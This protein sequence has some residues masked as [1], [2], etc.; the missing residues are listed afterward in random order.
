M[1]MTEP[2]VQPGPEDGRLA[3]AIGAAIRAAREAAGLTAIELARLSGV[4]QPHISR[5][6]NGRAEM[7]IPNLY[8]L[9]RALR[10][11][12]EIPLPEGG[13]LVVIPP[14]TE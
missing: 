10:A 1:A 13:R 11:P 9:V 6:E 2:P 14:K 3:V 5:A 12:L 8:K 7:G 4:H